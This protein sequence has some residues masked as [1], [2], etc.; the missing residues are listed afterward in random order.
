M[1][2][3]SNR[4]VI[5]PLVRPEEF[6]PVLGQ[7]VILV[8]EGVARELQQPE[9]VGGMAEIA[10]AVAHDGP[11]AFLK[12]PEQASHEVILRACRS[13]NEYWVLGEECD[14]QS[15]KSASAL[16]FLF[17]T[18]SVPPSMGER[19]S[20]LHAPE[21]GLV[22]VFR[23]PTSGS[24]WNFETV[25]LSNETDYKETRTQLA[26]LRNEV[27]LPAKHLSVEGMALFEEHAIHYLRK[28]RRIISV[29][30]T[31]AVMG[32]AALQWMA[33]S[34]WAIPMADVFAVFFMLVGSVFLWGKQHHWNERH[35]VLLTFAAAVKIQALW[36]RA[37]LTAEVLSAQFQLR[38]L[39]Q[40]GWVRE[41]LRPL[42]WLHQGSGPQAGH[43]SKACLEQWLPTE[44]AHQQAR[45]ES[46]RR[47]AQWLT[48]SV[49]SAYG[50]S[51][52]LTVLMVTP[53]DFLNATSVAQGTSAAL[54]LFSSLGTLLLIFNGVMG[55]GARAGIHQ[56]M[57]NLLSRAT[58]TLSQ[59]LDEHEYDE[60]LLD[61]GRE[62][63]Q[64]AAERGMV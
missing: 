28:V 33:M 64:S 25:L 27:G 6:H 24:S 7:W 32:V 16:A 61:L 1:E 44:L 41:A 10:V 9:S 17:R 12:L 45:S 59:G 37:N 36:L 20:V 14:D 46:E 29:L 55:Y 63:I 26:W 47:K 39:H 15:S 40:Y 42:N 51:A 31:L 23:R 30:F 60:L 18:E 48:T 62:S 53:L 21:V 52:V 13:A 35:H 50:I 4:Q 11:T 2:D 3:I 34:G 19:R 43:K 58:T 57:A 22:K 49:Y 54:G 5:L 56:H 8:S 38:Q